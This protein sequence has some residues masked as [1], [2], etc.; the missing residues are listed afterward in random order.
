MRITAEPSSPFAT[1]AAA[2]RSRFLVLGPSRA[3]RN[4]DTFQHTEQILGLRRWWAS[5]GGQPVGTFDFGEEAETEA[6]EKVN[7]QEMYA[8][9]FWI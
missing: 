3:Y 6:K 2:G 9:L 5:S 4:H 1:T 7:Q 8:Y